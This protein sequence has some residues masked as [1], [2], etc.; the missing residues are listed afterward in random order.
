MKPRGYGG[1]G[2]ADALTAAR[3][4]AGGP[5]GRQEPFEAHA[6]EAL[7]SLLSGGSAGRPAQAEV[8]IVCEKA[9]LRRGHA[10]PG[11][12]CHIVGGGPVPVSWVRE[13]RSN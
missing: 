4:L 3:S 10:H 6:A 13:A 9:A 11:E 1:R 12:V 5:G 2:L 8:V 7:V